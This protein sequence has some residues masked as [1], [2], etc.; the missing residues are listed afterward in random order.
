MRNWGAR[1]MKQLSV[2]AAVENIFNQSIEYRVGQPSMGRIYSM[3][4]QGS[5]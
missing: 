2:S 1:V 3:N 5:F 4:L